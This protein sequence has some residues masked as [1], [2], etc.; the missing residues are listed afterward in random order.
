MKK[1]LLSLGLLLFFLVG[2]E[3]KGIQ[4]DKSN[5]DEKTEIADLQ[6]QIEELK[7][8]LAEHKIVT[9]F[10]YNQNNHTLNQLLY[11]DEQVEHLI[12]HLPDVQRK[13]G[14][15][16][17]INLTDP[18]ITLRVQLVEMIEDPSLPNNY[19]LEFLEVDNLIVGYDALIYV[20]DGVDR[21][22]IDSIDE[23]NIKIKEHQ[24]LFKFTMI[25]EHAV[26][27]SEQYLP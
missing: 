9:E 23:F 2:C 20:L 25:N 17:Q 27:I 16:E 8:Q 13:F 21:V 14:Y 11:T 6:K 10:Q 7:N 3:E 15:I 26:S 18:D 5:A 24:R 1:S 12:K 22:K 19:R 4:Q